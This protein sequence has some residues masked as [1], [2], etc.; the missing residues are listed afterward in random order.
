MVAS[1]PGAEHACVYV[2][3]ELRPMP[4]TVG[5]GWD[6][7]WRVLL[8]GYETSGVALSREAAREEALRVARTLLATRA[9]RTAEQVKVSP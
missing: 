4:I 3:S 1:T 7:H 6:Y 2:H 5:N 8:A 9:E